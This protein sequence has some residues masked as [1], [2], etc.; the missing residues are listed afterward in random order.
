[1]K[2]I[3]PHFGL[4]KSKIHLKYSNEF[5]KLKQEYIHAHYYFSYSLIKIFQ[6]KV[7]SLQLKKKVYSLIVSLYRL[8][9]SIIKIKVFMARGNKQFYPLKGLLQFQKHIFIQSSWRIKVLLKS[10]LYVFDKFTYIYVYI[11]IHICIFF[12]DSSQNP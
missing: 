11:H 3:E 6:V 8:L 12:Q 10:K 4:G 1:M 5:Q 2:K 9:L 7:I